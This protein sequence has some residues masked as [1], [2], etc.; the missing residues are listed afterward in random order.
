MGITGLSKLQFDLL[1]KLMTN[2]KRFV[3]LSSP[4]TGKT[5][6]YGIAILKQVDTT[7]NHPQVLCLCSTYESAI[8]TQ[9]ILSQM[10][11]YSGVVIGSAVQDGTSKFRQKTC[12]YL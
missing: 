11:V 8:Q 6:A 7:K 12:Y 3:H 5:I 4:G 9:N 1:S 2:P 10:A